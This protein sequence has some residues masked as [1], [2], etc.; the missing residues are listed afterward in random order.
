MSDTPK[1]DPHASLRGCFKYL[2][3]KLGPD[4]VPKPGDRFT[5]KECGRVFTYEVPTDAKGMPMWRA[6]KPS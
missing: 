3:E 2:W 6:G 5:C 4:D 1:T